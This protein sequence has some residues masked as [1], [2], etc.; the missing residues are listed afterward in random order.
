[1]IKLGCMSLSY[2]RA[3][4]EG[5]MDLPAFIDKAY[6]LGLDGIDLHTGAFASEEEDYLRD[7][8]MRCLKRGLAISYI[9]ISNNFGK[10]LT[11]LPDEI[12]KVKHWIDVAEQM[13]VPMVR[14]FAAWER[15]DEDKEVIWSRMIDCIKAVMAYAG[16]KGI[17][18]GLHNHNHGCVT[19]TGD[20]VI[21]ILEEVDHPYFFT[22]HGYRSV[23]RFAGRFG[24][25]GQTGSQ[26]RFLRQHGKK[27]ALCGA[28]T[29]QNLPNS[30]GRRSLAGL[31][32]DSQDYSQCE[33]QR[34]DVYRL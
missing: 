19:R 1:M 3:L 8:R 31:P 29:R 7:I 2:N 11:D 30:D 10:P 22:Y 6:E 12:D 23:C 25:Q 21:R 17:V 5:R 34:L 13:R 27:R 4:S 24:R 20:D 28:C 15:E 26:L 16:E 33:F 9:G 14:I 32:E 18:V